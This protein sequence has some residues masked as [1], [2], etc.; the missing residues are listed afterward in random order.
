MGLEPIGKQI[1]KL[2]AGDSVITPARGESNSDIKDL[3]KLPVLLANSKTP[4]QDDTT[5]GFS[6]ERSGVQNTGQIKDEN[7]DELRAEKA[8]LQEYITN[9]P[10]I[11]EE[12]KNKILKR[13]AEI[14]DAENKL[15]QIDFEK[16]KAELNTNTTNAPETPKV[17]PKQEY[18]LSRIPEYL[19]SDEVNNIYTLLHDATK[20]ETDPTMKATLK[21]KAD[22]YLERLMNMK[23]DQPFD[24]REQ[25]DKLRA[26]YS[27]AS[28]AAET[29]T[30]P[31]T[32]EALRKEA[33]I[34]R[35]A[36]M[37]LH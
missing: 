29:A 31:A 33:E 7:I 25:Y 10:N 22:A 35:Q 11:S 4:V 27:E 12:E 9:N 24:G 13:L 20:N 32:K 15:A 16:K 3:S 5:M 19:S 21:A 14:S 6:I 23:D 2:V 17:Q 18:P 36:L 28:K 1:A 37:H 26:S 8:K 34:Y 30:N